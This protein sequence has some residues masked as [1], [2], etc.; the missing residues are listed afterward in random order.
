MQDLAELLRTERLRRGWTLHDVSI[1][2]HLSITVLK[3]LEEGRFESI[4]APVFVE[5]H[6]RNY[7]TV[8]E[9]DAKSPG[10]G[11]ANDVP[12]TETDRKPAPSGGKVGGRKS[13]VIAFLACCGL[14]VIFL[15][16]SLS[17]WKGLKTGIQT[18]GTQPGAGE[19]QA[20]K[21]SRTLSEPRIEGGEQ[22]EVPRQVQLPAEKPGPGE[23]QAVKISRTLSEPRIEG[24]EQSEVPRQVQLP[25]E[26]P[27]P[28]NES[29][30]PLSESTPAGPSSPANPAD[31]VQG[32]PGPA[33]TKQGL[34]P[35]P[36]RVALQANPE[37]SAQPVA[38][39]GKT[40]HHLE[41]QADQRT[42]VQVVVDEGNSE[43]E[44][45]QPGEM[46]EWKPMERVRVVIGN[47][48]GVRIKW[49]GKPVEISA[50]TGRVVRL[51]LPMP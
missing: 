13:A 2:T 44:L 16:L 27:G 41:I 10:H 49:D 17:G 1:R 6:L 33:V 47:G 22:P 31:S 15:G 20:V 14:A 25:A 28:E 11:G 48:G 38:E 8:L 32:S 18:W 40:N 19:D 24:G 34:E 45:L 35:Q 4:G 43:S 9:I 37:V 51:T 29:S 39:P 23:D 7:S 42:W 3:A 12:G 5:R 46:G 50:K 30:S 36:D 26:K 21:I